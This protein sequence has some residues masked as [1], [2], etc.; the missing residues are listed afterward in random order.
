MNVLCKYKFQR[1]TV[2]YI[3]HGTSSMYMYLFSLAYFLICR[4]FLAR[5]ADVDAKNKENDSPIEV[6]LHVLIGWGETIT[7]YHFI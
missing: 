1:I 6:I 2:L 7:F 3:C 5:G 4:L